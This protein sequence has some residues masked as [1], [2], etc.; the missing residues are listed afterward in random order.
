[1]TR[2]WEDRKDRVM[3]VEVALKTRQE[4]AAYLRV[5]IRKLDMIAADGTIPRVKIGKRTLFKVVDLNDYIRAH[6]ETSQED[7]DAVAA[8]IM[9]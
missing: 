4:A 3:E 7:A 5:G 8:R 6:T 2:F 1:M 9:S